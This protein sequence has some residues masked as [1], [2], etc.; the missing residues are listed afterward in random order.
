MISGIYVIINKLTKH[1]YLGSSINIEKRWRE[2][3]RLL[4]L[5][6]HHSRPLQSAYNKYGKGCLI[7]HILFLCGKEDLLFFEQL[8]LDIENPKYNI[9]KAANAPM[10]GRKHSENTLNK[11][12]KPKSLEHRA[13]IAAVRKGKH[14][15]ETHIRN[16]VGFSGKKHSEESKRKMAISARNRN[17]PITV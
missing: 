1:Y 12:R 3:N 14:L 9:S 6:K 8:C 15:S 5:N 13:K 11:M 16:L 4:K 17:K 2:H 7:Y 10:A